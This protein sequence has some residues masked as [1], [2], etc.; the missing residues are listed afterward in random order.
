MGT[1]GFNAFM[2][3]EVAKWHDEKLVFKDGTVAAQ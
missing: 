3:A 1:E 2:R